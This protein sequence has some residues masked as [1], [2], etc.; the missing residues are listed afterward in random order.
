MLKGFNL[1][2]EPN[3]SVAI[4]GH[5]GSGKSTIIKLLNQYLYIDKGQILI[6]NYDISQIDLKQLRSEILIINQSA[7]K[8]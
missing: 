7:E 2:I 3:Q 6:D 1:R 4:V 8:M 5:S